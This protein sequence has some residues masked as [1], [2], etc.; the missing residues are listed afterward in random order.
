MAFNSYPCLC[1]EVYIE[2]ILRVITVTLYFTSGLANS[3]Y[4]SIRKIHY[5]F[6][7]SNHLAQVN[8][9]KR[10]PFSAIWTLIVK[11]ISLIEPPTCLYSSC[12]IVLKRSVMIC[13]YE[14]HR[15]T[16]LFQAKSFVPGLIH[17]LG[18]RVLIV[19]LVL[20]YFHF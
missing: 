13:L 6:E 10:Y 18:Y 3:S 19:P 12:K 17:R 20:K 2:G 14:N 9:H 11:L 4:Y 8:L 15:N 1:S 16:Y 7:N 5:A